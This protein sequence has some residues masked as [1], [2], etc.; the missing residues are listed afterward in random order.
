[1]NLI[2]NSRPDQAKLVGRIAV[3]LSEIANI[4]TYSDLRTTKLMYC[5]VEADLTFRISMTRAIESNMLLNELDR[6]AFSD[7]YSFTGPKSGYRPRL[8]FK[9]NASERRM[10]EEKKKIKT[11]LSEKEEV[12]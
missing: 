9:D 4:N 5:S 2:S 1:M 12:A 6:S 8:E 7:L 11:R 3:D 10:E